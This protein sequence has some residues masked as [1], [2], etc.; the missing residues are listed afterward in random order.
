[1]NLIM[2]PE[3][4][5]DLKAVLKFGNRNSIPIRFEFNNSIRFDS[6]W[7]MSI[8]F[9]SF[10]FDSWHFYYMFCYM[11][12]FCLFRVVPISFWFISGSFNV[13]RCVSIL[14]VSIQF[15]LIEFEFNKCVMVRFFFLPF[16]YNATITLILKKAE[17]YIIISLYRDNNHKTLII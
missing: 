12:C 14:F 2:V 11:V 13:S 10:I 9:N 15:G 8:L 6:W 4:G 1:M 3:A 7:F 5:F 16:E 17:V